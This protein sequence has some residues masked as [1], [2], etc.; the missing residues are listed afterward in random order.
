VQFSKKGHTYKLDGEPIR[1]VTTILDKGFPKPALVT[2]AA[3]ETAGYAVDHWGELAEAPPSARLRTLERAAF[4]RRD[5]A[6]FRGTELHAIGEALGSGEAVTVP[7][8]YQGIAQRYA[9]WLDAWG[10]EIIEAERPVLW[11]SIEG[12][13]VSPP[14]A[15]TFDLIADLNDGCR[16]LLD[17]K[18]GS[19]VYE[20]H[21]LQLAAYRYAT[22][23][24]AEDG[25]RNMLAIDRCGV[26][27]VTP[28]A[29]RLIPV[30]ADRMAWRV[31]MAARISAEYA[32]VR[33]A[34]Y[35]D[36]RE[37]PVGRPIE[38]GVLAR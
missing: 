14:Y 12:D 19:G 9:D 28:D 22:H 29:V 20:S 25:M 33:R 2:W 21:V 18:T 27:H 4:E 36:K 35:L 23:L 7:E 15:G 30:S 5:K 17:I 11:V 31:F 16:W 10:A 3:K 1:S 13:T 24:L 26:I 37:W 38:P 6:A 34:A 8:H 32:V